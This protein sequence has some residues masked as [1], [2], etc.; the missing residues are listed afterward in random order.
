MKTA[1]IDSSAFLRLY[2]PDGPLPPALEEHVTAAIR[3]DAILLAPELAIAEVAQVLHK[4]EFDRRITGIEADEILDA[5][6]ALPVRFVSHL[7]LAPDAMKLAR[8][9]NLSV[10]DG[11]FIALANKYQVDLI[12]ADLRLERA[13]R[14]SAARK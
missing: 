12:T 14:K 3:A 6:L 2:I 1:V 8:K 7:D 11:F 5:F 13:F 4:K 9:H 10:Y